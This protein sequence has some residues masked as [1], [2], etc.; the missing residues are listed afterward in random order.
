MGVKR[1]IRKRLAGNITHVYRNSILCPILPGDGC[2]QK[3]FFDVILNGCIPLVPIF[4]SSK[5][6]KREFPY[7]FFGHQECSTRI[8][9]PFAK[10]TFWR[11][12][13]AGL[14]IMDFVLPYDGTCCLKCMADPIVKMMANKT[15]LQELRLRLRRYASLATFRLSSEDDHID[16]ESY[17]FPDAFTAALV[18][19]RHYLWN[20]LGRV[21]SNLTTTE[22]KD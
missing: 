12:K 14:D 20:L 1:S 8:T 2:A 7:S 6:E 16:D 15:A 21:P 19:V 4:E 5:H 11:S 10:G 3:R 22:Q 17:H 9:Y 18:S 13:T